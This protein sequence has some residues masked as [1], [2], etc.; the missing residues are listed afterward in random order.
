MQQLQPAIS[1]ST[2]SAELMYGVMYGVEQKNAVVFTMGYPSSPQ[3]ESAATKKL[4]VRGT[5]ASL[6]KNESATQ[7]R[8]DE[9]GH[10]YAIFIEGLAL[11]ESDL[12]QMAEKLHPLPAATFQT[13]DAWTKTR[14]VLPA[15]VTIYK[16]TWLPK[17]YGPAELVA[18]TTTRDR[19]SSYTVL[20]RASQKD[21][22]L[23]SLGSGYGSWGNFPPPDSQEKVTVLG[24]EANLMISREN[25][26]TMSVSWT[27]NRQTYHV[28]TGGALTR[29]ELLRIANSLVPVPAAPMP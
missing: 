16:P 20:T 15:D 4:T 18:V 6:T 21:T 14:G 24:Q 2:H 1:P 29:D 23:F 9:Q 8:W 19:V 27:S 22:I 12:L 13:A 26:N 28:R 11:S 7:L 17:G 3:R 5:T 25:N 10:S